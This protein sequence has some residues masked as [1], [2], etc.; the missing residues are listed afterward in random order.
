MAPSQATDGLI[1][2]AEFLIRIRFTPRSSPR[3][4]WSPCPGKGFKQFP[5]EVEATVGGQ[6][7]SQRAQLMVAINRHWPVSIGKPPF[8]AADHIARRKIE[9]LMERDN[10]H[11]STKER[12]KNKKQPTLRCGNATA[13]GHATW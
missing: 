4:K 2:L 9:L 8:C 3:S 6:Q 12:G 5:S 10:D 11:D 1:H 7:M 13:A